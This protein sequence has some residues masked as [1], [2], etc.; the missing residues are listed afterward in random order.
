MADLYRLARLFRAIA[1]REWNT[2]EEI[3]RHLA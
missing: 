3:A 2:A 1:A